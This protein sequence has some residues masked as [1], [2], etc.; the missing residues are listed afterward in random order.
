MQKE[1]N[2]IKLELEYHDFQKGEIIGTEFNFDRFSIIFY[3]QM[4][5][6]NYK[7]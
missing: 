2:S 3:P 6:K 4:V 1:E 7:I 5:T